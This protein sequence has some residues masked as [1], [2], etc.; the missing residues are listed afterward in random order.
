M[1]PWFLYFL[2]RYRNTVYIGYI[3]YIALQEF[4]ALLESRN[5]PLFFR[6][7]A[8]P[9]RWVWCVL[10]Y[11]FYCWFCFALV[12]FYLLC[13]Q[14]EGVEKK[15]RR[16]HTNTRKPKQEKIIKKHHRG[17]KCKSQ[18]ITL[19]P[20]RRSSNHSKKQT[21]LISS[22]FFFSVLLFCCFEWS[23]EKVK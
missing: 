9:H 5:F 21:G 3:R 2:Q 7:F 1:V 8:F 23:V 10:F 12:L 15:K 11:L 20:T 17:K 6:G 22:F 16:K 19:K 18:T 14:G 4:L 13:G